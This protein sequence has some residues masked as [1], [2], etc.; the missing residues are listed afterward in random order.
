MPNKVD[1]IHDAIIRE[2]PGIKD[3]D[4]WAMAWSTYNKMKKESLNKLYEN[5]VTE[6]ITVSPNGKLKLGDRVKGDMPGGKGKI[7]NISRDWIRVRDIKGEIHDFDEEDL[8]KESIDRIYK[9]IKTEAAGVPDGWKKV[10]WKDGQGKKFVDLIPEDN[11]N[12]IKLNITKGGGSLVKIE[13]FKEAGMIK[14]SRRE[15]EEDNASELMEDF[16]S[17]NKS[18]FRQFVDKEYKNFQ[19]ENNR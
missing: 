12:D 19:K 5:V 14:M 6:G 16:I 17:K 2:N 10:T 8:Q 13:S 1:E 4:A 3:K 15:F 18:A 7:I 11:L 9:N